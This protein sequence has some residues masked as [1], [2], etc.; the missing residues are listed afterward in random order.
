MERNETLT[1]LAELFRLFGDPTRLRILLKLEQEE[2]RVG[3]LAEALGMTV[4]AVSHQLRVLKT[5]RLVR[6]NR[7]GKSIRYALDD[8]HVHSLVRAALEHIEE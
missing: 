1:E 6:G 3:E 4:S 7:E 5:G 2:C 8:E